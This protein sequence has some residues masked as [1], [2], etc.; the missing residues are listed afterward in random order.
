MWPRGREREGEGEVSHCIIPDPGVGERLRAFE[1]LGD[2]GE[3]NILRNF[4]RCQGTRTP[5]SITFLMSL[6]S[7][8]PR[9]GHDTLHCVGKELFPA[10][11]VGSKGAGSQNVVI[12]QA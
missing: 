9:R 11:K 3:R 7:C 10:Q 2:Y 6:H 5:I 1:R 4:S 8:M 12:I